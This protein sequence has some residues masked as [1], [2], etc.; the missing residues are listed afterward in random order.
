MLN[1]AVFFSVPDFWTRLDLFGVSGLALLVFLSL[2]FIWPR[3]LAL[4][5]LLLLLLLLQLHHLFSYFWSLPSTLP[6]AKVNTVL[7]FLIPWD[8]ELPSLMSIAP[9]FSFLSLFYCYS[10]LG[11]CSPV[12]NG[13][14]LSPSLEEK[15]NSLFSSCIFTLN[16]ELILQAIG[17]CYFSRSSLVLAVSRYVMVNQFSSHTLLLY[18]C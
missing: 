18:H 1:G 9:F 8:C 2:W 5:L 14:F 12:R 10:S 3:W 7:L 6:P 16:R 13:P 4:L 11:P 15:K 17:I